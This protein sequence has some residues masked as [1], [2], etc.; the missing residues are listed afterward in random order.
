MTKGFFNLATHVLMIQR[1]LLKE[2]E[3]Y[4]PRQ[5]KTFARYHQQKSSQT[6]LFCEKQGLV[7]NQ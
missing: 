5:I 2:E 4:K 6:V 1:L 3:K 7:E